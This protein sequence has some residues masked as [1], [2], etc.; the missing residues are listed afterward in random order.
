MRNEFGEGSTPALSRQPPR[1]RLGS[2]RARRLVH[3]H[4][5]QGDGP[6]DLAR[7]TR[8][9]STPGRR[10][11]SLTHG[12]RPQVIVNGMNKLRSYDLETGNVVWEAPG[13]TMNPIPSPVVDDG[14]R[15]PDERLPRQQP[16]GHPARRCERRSDGIEGHRSGSSTA[17]RRTCRRRSLYDG[18]LYFLKTN[19]GILSAFDARSGQAALPG[20]AARRS[21]A[22]CSRRPSARRARVYITGRDGVTLV[23]RNSPKLRSAREEHARG[24]LRCVARARGERRCIC[25]VL[26]I[27]LCRSYASN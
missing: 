16:E 25:E 22:K 27:P 7:Q 14:R 11:S 3:R 21:S 19:S 15:V 17:T 1:G 26:Q 23:L 10:R 18:I 5:R 2:L 20:P 6:R 24:R 13:T 12:G 9:R 4:A 8:R